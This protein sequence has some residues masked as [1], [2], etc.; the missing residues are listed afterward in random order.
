MLFIIIYCFL[1]FS[2]RENISKILLRAFCKSAYIWKKKQKTMELLNILVFFICLGRISFLA[3]FL[4]CL[5]NEALQNLFV[6]WFYHVAIYNYFCDFC[7]CVQ[8]IMSLLNE[9]FRVRTYEPCTL[10]HT[11]NSPFWKPVFGLVVII[12]TKI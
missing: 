9:H 6:I 10:Y 11:T 12:E 1:P 3:M 2:R 4:V 8:K 5:L 7:S